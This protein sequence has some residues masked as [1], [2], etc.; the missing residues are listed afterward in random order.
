VFSLTGCGT[1]VT[2]SS[3]RTVS[4]QSSKGMQD[5]L[6]AASQECRKHSR[7]ARW[8]S[9]GVQGFGIVGPQVYTFD[10]L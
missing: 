9:G 2:A 10:C 1:T 6:D 5:A 3:P 7:E 4:I 8:V